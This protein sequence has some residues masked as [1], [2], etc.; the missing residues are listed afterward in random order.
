MS[1]WVP[2]PTWT[3]SACVSDG[4]F[5]FISSLSRGNHTLSAWQP[6]TEDDPAESSHHQCVEFKDSLAR[7]TIEG[8]GMLRGP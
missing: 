5:I 2:P 3:V 7:D 1:E 8:P 6:H 4:Y